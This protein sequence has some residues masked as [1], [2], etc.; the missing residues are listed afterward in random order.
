MVSS[1]ETE[2]ASW[3]SPDT[4]PD[5]RKDDTLTYE[6]YEMINHLIRKAYQ[7]GKEDAAKSANT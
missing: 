1:H 7:Y 3:F 2:V 5:E 4:L 6:M